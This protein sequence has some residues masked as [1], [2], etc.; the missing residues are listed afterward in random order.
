MNPTAAEEPPS[1]PAWG[2]LDL[3]AGGQDLLRGS[4][5]PTR[6]P[7]VN[8]WKPHRGRKDSLRGLSGALQN[9][10]QPTGHPQRP[11]RIPHGA[12]QNA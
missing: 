5:G 9:G 10:Q 8:T 3:P 12:L 7:P 4:L 2:S 1:W 11:A 6:R